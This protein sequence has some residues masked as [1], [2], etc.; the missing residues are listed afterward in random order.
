VHPSNGL[1]ALSGGNSGSGAQ[2]N[3]STDGGNTWLA[4][5]SPN[6]SSSG[7]GVLSWFGSN[8][9]A[10]NSALYAALCSGGPTITLAKTTN[11]G[12]TWT[13]LTS[14][15]T[16]PGF[17]N[18]REYLWTDHF[19]G[20]PFFGRM[21]VSLT[22]FDSGGSGSYNAVAERFTTDEGATW[23]TPAA[24]N[25]SPISTDGNKQFL[26]LAVQPT[27][28]VVAMWE[29]ARCCGDNPTLYAGPGAFMWARSTDGGVSFPVSGTIYADTVA[30]SVPF[31]STSPGAFRWNPQPDIAADPIDGTLY[32]VWLSYRADNT[33][34]GTAVHL[35]KSTNNGATWSAPVLPFNNPNANLFQYMPWVGVSP[36]HVVHVTYSGGVTGNT[37]VAHFYTQSTD[38]GNT[39]STPFQ[40]ST[41]TYTPAGFM[42]DYQAL[43]LGGY[44]G[45]NG[46]ILATWTDTSAGENQWGRMGTFIVGT[47]TPTATPC[48]PVPCTS[49][50]TSTS[51]NTNTP[52][53]TPSPTATVCGNYSTT[54]AGGAI[55]T[56]TTD[57][58]NHA[59]D[60]VTNIALP[61][62]VQFYNNLSFTSANVSS[63]G[64]MQFVGSSASFT[65]DC[66]PSASVP[67]P[68]IYAHWDDLRTDQV[69]N[70][71]LYAGGCG[72]FTTVEGVAPNRIF[73]IEWR[74][75]EFANTTQRA[76]FEIRL[77][78]GQ[79]DFDIV[80]GILDAG[81]ASATIGS[82]DDTGSRFTQFECNLSAPANTNVHFSFVGCGPPNTATATITGTRPTDTPTRTFTTTPV[83]TFT[84]TNTPTRT[85]T[86]TTTPVA[87]CGAGADYTITQ[88]TG[89]TLV[90][91]TTDIGNHCDDCT[92]TITLPFAYSLYG[93]SFT[94]A[95]VSSNGTFQFGSN[96]A[97][98][99]NG[100]L[101]DATF[102]TTIF[103]FWDDLYTA[104][105][106]AGEGIFTSVSGSAPN[107]IFN[108]EWRVVYCCTGGTPINDFE[109]R[110][111]EGQN[112]FD[113]V[114]GTP[115]SDRASAT[116]GV[117][118][119]TGPQNSM[120][121]CNV[122]G[123]TSGTQLVFQEPPCGSP[124]AT[125]TPCPTCTNTPTS[126]FTPT[127]VLTS[128]PTNTPTSTRTNTTTP[129]AT[130]GPGADYTITQST[131]AIDPGV[132]DIGNHID[133]GITTIAL[134]FAYNVYGTAF[135][136]AGASSNGN[137]Q[138]VGT[139]TAFT[140]SCLP[141]NT[142]NTTIFPHWDDL[143]TDAQTGCSVFTSGCGIFTSTVGTAP[144]RVFNVEWRVVYF[145]AVAQAA[146]FE[147]R[148][149]EGQ[150]RFDIVYGQVDQT[151][152]S[153]T[154]GV[155]NGIGPQNTQ[156]ECNTGGLASGMVLTFR[157]PPCGTAT[158]TITG[159][160]PTNTPT[161][162]STP[163][164]CGASAGW[165][166][167]ANV[168]ETA[169]V[170]AAG[171]WLATTGKLYAM[172]GRPSD[173][174][175][176]DFTSP[177]VYD[178]TT[179]SWSTDT[180][181]TFPDNN[182]NNMAC[183][184]L[185]VGG[186]HKIYCVGGSFA[187]GISATSRVFA[188][189]PVAHTISTAGLDAWTGNGS[190]TVLPGGYAVVANKLYILGGFNINTSMTRAIY[191][192][193]PTAAPGSQWVLKSAQVPD[194][195]AGSN[196][197]GYI[198]A[199]AIGTSIYT[200]GGSHWDT[201]LGTI[202]DTATA[203][204]YDTLT[205]T[206]DDAGV[207]DMPSPGSAET[208]AFNVGGQL[209]VIGG[210]RTTPNP[211]ASVQIYDPGSNSWSVGT[212]FTTGRRNFS[213]DMDPVT[214][215]IYLAGGY[216][217]FPTP[218]N[219]TQIFTPA[220]T[221]VTATPTNTS[222]PSV[223]LLNTHLTWQQIPQGNA[224]S[225]RPMTLTL[226][227]GG[228]EFNYPTQNTDSNGGASWNV[229]GLPAGTYQ[230]RAKGPQF[231]ATCGNVV[232]PPAGTL[233]M[234]TQMGGDGSNAGVNN[235][236]VNSA[237]FNLLKLQFG[238]GGTN[239]ASDFNNDTV[240]NSTD[241]NILKNNF[242]QAGCSAIFA[243]P[244]TEA[245]GAKK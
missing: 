47:P 177:H 143:R 162:T 240:V 188:Y 215:K 218:M 25:V 13:A 146:N 140:N 192:F 27:G 213:V 76:N 225:I 185:V 128:T 123:P 49:T 85:F 53:N 78:E 207:A 5:P 28:A 200:G 235:N 70:C 227:L 108:I 21:Y 92:T 58:G 56:G 216:D 80:L 46:S 243:E 22:L 234:G 11:Q 130:C 244:P 100:C 83:A 41:A 152:T 165:S 111:Y 26:S 190:G 119:G 6:C 24:I 23:S 167:G 194:P 184:D 16:I 7:D 20:S 205:D 40:L 106:A 69:G 239:L 104:D 131:G 189:D 193:D 74:A 90:P 160:P 164:P 18:D 82:Q 147:V 149:Y 4:R 211:S 183:A 135:T 121:I 133:D 84:P 151:G 217:S 15:A 31:N 214:G 158:P 113:L 181:A 116:I 101:P 136:S 94:N 179:N 139:N 64:N 95:N 204:R 17:F 63:N 10:G 102:N 33:P 51:T 241:F 166:A 182:V 172:G 224:R 127:P 66:L 175:G 110:L 138:F 12:V 77:Y 99:I 223:V 48:S 68:T 105:T 229:A 198:P 219:T 60:L 115:M 59:D 67:G 30:R 39:W 71:T 233:E 54:T 61:F 154:V 145:A 57:T 186:S 230:W 124:T 176:S 132:N 238:S 9:N 107:R 210:G 42:G 120:F 72:I 168:N 3:N 237:D 96:N 29:R 226:K 79:R 174:A 50:P 196:G 91:G 75:V 14:Q 212:S 191:S 159:T 93:V 137:L 209:W 144:N 142:F 8:V 202:A 88:S 173:A 245:G 81:G 242:G 112:R 125:F 153:A 62:T 35:A 1:L 2:I 103:P 65:N 37:S 114:Y 208:R 161:R 89:A 109:I 171:V 117:Q 134:P 44:T 73:D 150:D 170:R 34:A 19:S 187:T 180:L 32:A 157:T 86:N 98:Y 43:S 163:T 222:T 220:T 122:A 232:L 178:P 38:G 221:C 236:I 169:M 97:T 156:F 155:Q 201:G 36:D 197:L 129:V 126:T 206:V 203:F 228:S 231:L 87:T 195:V 118:N 45:G 141:T 55:V 52:T 148:L 199:A